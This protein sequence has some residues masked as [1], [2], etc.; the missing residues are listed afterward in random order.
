[1]ARDVWSLGVIFYQLLTNTQPVHALNVSE[2]IHRFMQK[3]IK[4]DFTLINN[5][6]YA[7]QVLLKKMLDFNHHSRISIGYVTGYCWDMRYEHLLTYKESS[8]D[9]WFKNNRNFSK[10][11]EPNCY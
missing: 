6:P 7:I 4:I 8:V 5:Q 10:Y 2:L 9:T 3:S 11:S 1:M